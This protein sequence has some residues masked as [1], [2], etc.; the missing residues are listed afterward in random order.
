MATRS[1]VTPLHPVKGNA[2]QDKAGNGECV[3]QEGDNNGKFWVS[4]PAKNAS[5]SRSNDKS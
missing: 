1:E 4:K 2:V 3:T 5:S